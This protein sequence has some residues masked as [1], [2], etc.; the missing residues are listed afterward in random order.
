MAGAPAVSIVIVHYNSGAWLERCLRSL[1]AQSFPDFEAIIIDN[2]SADDAFAAARTQFAGDARFRFHALKENTGFARGSNMGAALARADWLAMLNPDA[3]ADSD[4]LTAFMRARAA[5]PHV[6]IF[7]STQIMA[8]DPSRYD[9][10]GDR[11]SLYGVAWRAG[12][13]LRRDATVDLSEIAFG[14]CGAGAFYETELFRYGLGYNPEFFCYME[15]IELAARFRLLGFEC[16]QITDAIIYHAGGQTKNRAFAHYHG[17][18]N[19]IWT[20]VRVMPGPIF[21][22]MLPVYISFFSILLASAF[23]SPLRR[24][25]LAALR[26]ALLGLPQAFRWRRSFFRHWTG[27]SREFARALVWNPLRVLR[28]GL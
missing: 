16:R 23:F 4:W 20:L 24:A 7:G 2:A 13:G 3:E 26:D 25:R 5:Y 12:H 22:P 21:W 14:P 17:V 10:L 1:V 9:G 19:S 28:R 27:S 8:D 18:R 11:Y 6:K 15:D